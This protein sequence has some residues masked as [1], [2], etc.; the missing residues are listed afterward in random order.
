MKRDEEKEERLSRA[1]DVLLRVWEMKFI[2]SLSLYVYFRDG[3]FLKFIKSFLTITLESLLPLGEFW[4]NFIEVGINVI[5]QV[6][7]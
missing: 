7:L 4:W 6:Q 5:V 1:E 2:L 3:K